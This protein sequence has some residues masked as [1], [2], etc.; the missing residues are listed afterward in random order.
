MKH[1]RRAIAHPVRSTVSQMKS[2]MRHCEFETGLAFDSYHRFH[3]FSVDHYRTFWR[4]FL[5]WSQIEHAGNADEVCSSDILHEAVFFPH[6]NLNYVRSLLT[7][8]GCSPGD[9]AIISRHWTGAVERLSRGAVKAKVIA[10][11]TALAKIG[12]D[13]D[14]R[15]ALIAF[16]DA[17]AA[18]AVLAA[19]ASGGAV[20]M[21]APDMAA[22][23]SIARLAAIEPRFLFCHG[24]APYDTGN[25]SHRQKLLQI[26]HA[27]PSLQAVVLLD[28]CG[29]LEGVTPRCYALDALI[30]SHESDDFAWPML[31]FNHPLYILFSSGTTGKPKGLVHGAG[32]TL[33]EHVKEHRL[34]CDLRPGDRMFFHTSTAWMMWSWA[35]TAL[36]SGAEVVLYD[37]AVTAPDTLWRIVSEQGVTVLGTS[38][39]YFQMCERTA[40][41]PYSGLDLSA[42][43]AVLSTGSILY[44]EQQE[45]FSRNIKDLPLQSISG[46]TDII[47]CFVMGNPDLPV[48]PGEPQ[49][50]GLGFDLRSLPID[51]SSTPQIGELVCGTPF[52]SRPVMLVGDPQRIRLYETYF[53]QNPGYWTQGDLV[54][55]TQEGSVVMH[56][57]SDGIITIRG[58]RIGPADIYRVLESFTEIDEAMAVEQHVH[59]ELG[60]TRIVLLVVLERGIRLTAELE[61]RVR[62][63]IAT[64]TSAAHVPAVIL[65]VAELPTT[66]TGKRSERSARD[67]V[68]NVPFMDNGALRNPECLV[69]IADHPS[70]R[71]APPQAPALEQRESGS[72]GYVPEQVLT[73]LWEKI[74][75]VQPIGRDED[76]FDIGGDSSTALRLLRLLESE[77]GAS[78]P[79]TIMYEAR[80]IARM[81]AILE[82][83]AATAAQEVALIKENR[84]GERLFIVH[85]LGGDVMELVPLARLIEHDGPVYV[86]RARGLDGNAPPLHS[87]EAMASAYLEAVRLI[88]P[89]GP[90]LLCGYSFGGLVAFDMAHALLDAGQAIGLLVLLDTTVDE[91]YW[92]RTA[93]LKIMIAVARKTLR[94]LSHT[95]SAVRR[96]YVRARIEG[97]RRRLGFRRGVLPGSSFGI[98]GEG[99]P[100]GARQVREAAIRA[101][102]AYEPSYYPGSLVFVRAMTRDPLMYDAAPL[103]KTLV[104]DFELHECSGDHQTMIRQPHVKRV[105]EILSVAL[106]ERR[107]FNYSKPDRADDKPPLPL[108]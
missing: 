15:I 81:A 16:N 61:A 12:L 40:T 2:F 69:A 57:R 66:H 71:A 1:S 99:L 41:E 107:S 64:N 79:I 88:Q 6:L 19:A 25:S 53:A 93:W 97:F 20:A 92:P 28:S 91:R 106:S 90:Y 5:E 68:N 43:R 75:G 48:Y 36:A 10:G 55:F 3:R 38:P 96:E 31:P 56:G 50:K 37:G 9:P 67:A 11:A 77:L 34:H 21:C 94:D 17:N 54:E 51:G 62:K 45:W 46:G 7:E 33:L 101:M 95:P 80:T 78:L 72:A 30:A 89:D 47:G 74:L 23:A 70:L 108:S 59:S 4:L 29:M 22:Q 13:R 100:A 42:L 85:G 39:A 102:S 49:C 63:A 35:L 18:I 52:P 32:G 26:I 44:P 83:K 14:T 84:G 104:S 76:F 60:H 58:I 87:V 8:S 103:W 86:I 98:G 105:A 73:H 65:Q 82:G 24:N 27:L